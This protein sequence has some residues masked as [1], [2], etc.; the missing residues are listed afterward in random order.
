MPQKYATMGVGCLHG[1]SESIEMWLSEMLEPKA[2]V[3]HACLALALSFLYPSRHLPA[4]AFRIC[5]LIACFG[6]LGQRDWTL[7]ELKMNSTAL[8]HCGWLE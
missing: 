7:H 4:V 5:R 2:V 1:S 6:S 3:Q 8:A